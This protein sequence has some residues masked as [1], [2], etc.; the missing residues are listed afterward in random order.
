MKTD[1][2]PK[3]LNLAR[4]A[5]HS[6][7]DAAGVQIGCTEG[8]V[9]L[10]LDGDSR[11]IILEAGEVFAATEHRRALIY[12][13]QPSRIS[14]V[15]PAVLPLLDRARPLGYVFGRHGAGG[16]EAAVHIA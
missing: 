10:T 7:R 5:I 12:A 13:M 9:W 14:L 15:S 1:S 4:H 11:D 3:D 16:R 2:L 6:L 8:T